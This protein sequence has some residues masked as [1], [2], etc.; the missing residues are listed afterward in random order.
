[1][2]HLLDR[3]DRH[4]SGADDGH[5]R[6]PDSRADRF[7]TPSKWTIAF[8]IAS[9]CVLCGAM[10]PWFLHR[11]GPDAVSY[12]TIA[13][14]YRAWEFHDAVNGYWSPLLSWLLAPLLCVGAPGN[15]TAK[16]L[17]VAIG[18][19]GLGAVWWLGK[20]LELAEPARAWTTL[21]VLPAV[22]MYALT[23]TTPDLLVAVI[24]AGSIGVVIGIDYPRSTWQ[25]AACG[26]L[27]ALAYLAKAYAFPFFLAH[28]FTVSCYL[29]VRRRGSRED[30]H[31][32]A[33]ATAAGLVVF[34]VVAGGW[35]SL[36]SRKYSRVTIGTTGAYQFRIGS[37]GHPTDVGGLYPPPNDMAVSAWEDPSDLR[38]PARTAITN[39]P[40]RPQP[41]A[42]SAAK[43]VK[44]SWYAGWPF[45]RELDRIYKNGIR[46]GGTLLRLS[47][48]SP[49][50][51]LGLLISCWN[52]PRGVV[53]DRWVILISTLLLYPAGYLMIFI[54]E[55]FFWLI[56]FLLSL[57]AGLLATAVPILRRNPWRSCWAVV[58]VLSLAAWPAWILARLSHHVLEATPLVAAQLQPMM[59][60]GT[61]I[62]SDRE[63]GVTNNIAFHLDARYY[64]LLRPNAS[65]EEQ[66]RQLREHRIRYLFVWG[67]P[68]R[69]P[70]L[71]S[72]RE[73]PAEFPGIGRYG[74]D[75]R[76]FSLRALSAEPTSTGDEG[77]E[78]P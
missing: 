2:Q 22:A 39:S 14:K 72:C 64:G 15:V 1:M 74:Y 26:L 43:P 28:Y 27:G 13:R 77:A 46:Y 56:T 69:Y 25:G 76:V 23:D 5:P 59:P 8:I 61:R 9:Y 3:A 37:Q 18:A 20:R 47:P 17:Q 31:R 33:A 34:A 11:A 62:A 41:K 65:A 42:E 36:L 52:M 58:V 55:R 44:K 10:L 7:M 53:R 54:N 16:C 19:A 4:G 60:P 30:L 73:V 68:S 75:L 48:L 24:L 29:F 45:I 49:V 40:A 63:W 67:D 66:E 50:I 6:L 78:L 57:A 71:T 35:A 32:L 38:I 70:F 51:L 21:A 12:I